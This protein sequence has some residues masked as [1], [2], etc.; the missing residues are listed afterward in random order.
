MLDRERVKALPSDDVARYAAL[1]LDQGG[2]AEVEDFGDE[3]RDMDPYP[4][5]QLLSY[6]HLF[7]RFL[8][9]RSFFRDRAVLD[10]GCG[11]GRLGT[12]MAREARRYVGIE[13]SAALN[14]FEVPSGVVPRVSLVRGSIES[15]PVLAG[16]ADIVVCWG[17][18]H[19]VRNWRPALDEMKRVLAPGG[20]LLV[21]VYPDAYALR[22]NLNRLLSHVDSADFQDW[23]RWMLRTLRRW[24]ELDRPLVQEL[25][26]RLC[27]GLRLDTEW[28]LFQAFDGL[29][30]AYH[31]LLEQAIPE[32]FP[33]PWTVTETHSGCFRID[34]P[35]K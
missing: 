2:A 33:A 20:T 22:E 4:R 5:L 6:G 23:C 3:W 32:S 29:G 30:P 18:L 14:H 7:G 11:N 8:L 35:R 12:F 28:E 19:H 9:P 25:S 27:V 1:D 21:Y 31:H 13:L 10:L 17:V 16:S 34:A 15:L 24:G 26:R